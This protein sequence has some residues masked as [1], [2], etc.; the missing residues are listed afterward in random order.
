MSAAITM[1]HRT[2]SPKKRRRDT[3]KDEAG[4]TLVEIIAVLV[5]LGILA[6]VAVP[7]YFDLQSKA[8]EKALAGAI[9]EANG[10]VTQYF[11]QQILEGVAHDAIDYTA[12]NVGANLGDFT[13]TIANGEAASASA[14]MTLTVTGNTGTALD[15]DTQS[16]T[17]PRPG[18]P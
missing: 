2:D 15:G 17:I 1:D 12:A 10:R 18:A 16:K 14:T 7:K 11:G 4:F 13:L 8:K 6:A 3:S 9:A 5:I